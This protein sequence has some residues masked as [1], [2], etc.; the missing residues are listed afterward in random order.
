M[1]AE[2]LVAIFAHLASK[3][4]NK[5]RYLYFPDSPLKNLG[6]VVF[7]FFVS[8]RSRALISESREEKKKLIMYIYTVGLHALMINDPW[9]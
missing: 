4:E 9:S 2:L 3:K 6:H 8:R 5:I 7:F 1:G